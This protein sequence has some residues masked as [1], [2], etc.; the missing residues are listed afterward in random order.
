[1][2]QGAL[3]ICI[4]N[5]SIKSSGTPLLFL[6]TGHGNT[7]PVL[8]INAKHRYTRRARQVILFGEVAGRE[9]S[10]SAGIHGEEERMFEER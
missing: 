9:V 7:V 8:V 6:E 4:K 10:A 3:S 5:Q 1:M 2:F